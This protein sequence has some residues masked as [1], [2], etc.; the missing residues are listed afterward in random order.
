MRIQ[1]ALNGA[2]PADTPHLPISPEAMAKDAIA[3]RAAGADC[4]HL[5]PRDAQAC[6]SLFPED[7]ARVINAIRPAVPGMAIGISTGDWI[8]PRLGRLRDM[9]SWSV[10]PD[11]VSVNL[12]E[13]DAGDVLA[14][15]RRRGIGI[16]L[17]LS[18][19]ADLER[20]IAMPGDPMRGAVRVMIEMNTGS[21]ATARHEAGLLHR[22]LAQVM[23]G[24]P[25]LLHGFEQS[26]W[27]FVA[28][29]RDWGC[30]TRIGLEDV[31]ALPGGVPADN[32]QIVARA[33]A[34]LDGADPDG[35]SGAG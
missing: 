7:V 28:L 6:E 19:V 27:E 11:F 8:T 34:I 17:G 22:M 4:L 13:P 10:L 25:Q 3:C 26:A 18:S 21:F 23:P 20:L 15:M 12:A 29:A 5:H 2:R 1:A 16:E 14:L 24:V 9:E 33:R 32:A 31:L 35:A 30:Q